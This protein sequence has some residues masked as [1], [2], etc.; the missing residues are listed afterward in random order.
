LPLECAAE[1][2]AAAEKRRNYGSGANPVASRHFGPFLPC[3]VCPRSADGVRFTGYA[4]NFTPKTASIC[5]LCGKSLALPPEYAAG[6]MAAA[7]IAGIMVPGQIWRRA[8]ISGRFPC[9]GSALALRTG[10]RFTGY[11]VNIAPKTVNICPLCGKSPVLPLECADAL[12]I[13]CEKLLELWLR[14]KNAGIRVAARCSGRTSPVASFG[15]DFETEPV[16]PLPP[17]WGLPLAS[18]PRLRA[19]PARRFR[20]GLGELPRVL[21]RKLPVYAL[22]AENLRYNRLN[23]PPNL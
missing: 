14:R 8:G 6:F 19:D 23:M 17:A 12:A 4:V 9:M 20:L 10:I 2:M 1:F 16:L 15:C 5:P 7:K 21:L 22:F 3:R 11:A 13:C 18:L